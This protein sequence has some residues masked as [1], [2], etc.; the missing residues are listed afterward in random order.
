MSYKRSGARPPLA[1]AS[2]LLAFTLLLPDIAAA[3]E[4][5]VT[6]VEPGVMP[7]V[8]EILTNNVVA[9]LLLI[10][11]VSGIVIEV[12][13]VGSFGAFGIVGV[14]SFLLYFAGA[15]M[16]GNITGVEVM[17]FIAGFIL[18]A[19]EIFVVPGFGL[20]GGLGIIALLSALI[21]AAPEPSSAIWSMLVA[22][23][24]SV[25][26]IAFTL[27]NRKTRNVWGKLVLFDKQRN[28]D[29]FVSNDSSLAQLQGQRGVALTTLRPAGMAM[30]DGR[31]V[32]VV[33]SGEFIEAQAAVEVTLIE[34]TRVVVREI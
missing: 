14:V 9:T 22:I 3:A 28:Q 11:G 12:V 7:R 23:A 13:T 24:V 17:L 18:L 20:T 34:G 15:A 4:V 6:V 27:K 31:K 32:D 25:A 1:A 2:L 30:I 33:S 10:L 16:A 5:G 29:G 19:A 8:A 21:L 26:V